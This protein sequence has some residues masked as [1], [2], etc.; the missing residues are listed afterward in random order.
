VDRHPLYG[1]VPR[2]RETFTGPD[3]KVHE[4]WRHDPDFSPRL[5]RG[6]VRGDVH[7]QRFCTAHYFPK[8]FYVDEERRCVQCGTDFIFA[9]TEQKYWYESLGFHFDSVPIRCAACRRRR[10]TGHALRE[11]IAQARASL[12]AE[13]PNSGANLA[14]ARALVEHH[15]RTGQGDLDE[16]VAAARKAA[17][18]FPE[19]SEP[20][21][22]EGVAQLRAGRAARGRPLLE[23]FL[24]RPDRSRGRLAARAQSYLERGAGAP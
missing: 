24:S 16:A 9:A 11:Q 3:G 15:E 1:D 8:Y 20:Q 10:R 13:G 12:R 2:V 18:V 6:A 19:S 22:W 4:W 23:A 7:K 21:F 5:P 17:A 14:L